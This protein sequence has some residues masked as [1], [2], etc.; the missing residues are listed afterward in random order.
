VGTSL[1]DEYANEIMIAQGSSHNHQRWPG[2]YHDHVVQCFQLAED[3]YKMLSSYNK[4]MDFSLESALIVLYFHDI[5][6]IFKYS[7]SGINKRL[8]ESKEAWYLGI[9]PHKYKIVLSDTQLDALK[10]I[11]GEGDDYCKDKR[12]M[13]P[14][15]AFCHAVDTM[16][17]RIFHHTK[18]L[19]Y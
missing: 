7:D 2:G 11:H 9:L 4:T 15:A 5:E 1:H 10:Y 12:V 19:T 6:K 13:S 17:A 16:S 14:L 8:I 3:L 18:F